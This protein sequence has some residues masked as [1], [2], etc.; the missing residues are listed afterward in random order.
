MLSTLQHADSCIHPKQNVT[1]IGD[2]REDKMRG[3]H[4]SVR[5]RVWS[6]EAATCMQSSFCRAS[7]S[8]GVCQYKGSQNVTFTP[9]KNLYVH[10]CTS[11]LLILFWISCL[12]FC[13]VC[14]NLLLQSFLCDKLYVHNWKCWVQEKIG[15]KDRWQGG[16]VVW[17]AG[18]VTKVYLQHRWAHRHVPAYHPARV[19]RY[20]LDRHE[21]GILCGIYTSQSVNTDMHRCK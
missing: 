12:L 11:S 5:N 14:I 8:L 10:G 3:S 9:F 18:A 20:T 16:R 6:L 17:A 7:T 21:P 4:L 15:G 1:D 2:R 13:S 19:H